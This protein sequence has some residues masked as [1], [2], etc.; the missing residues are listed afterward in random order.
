[1]LGSK[2]SDKEYHSKRYLP[3][4]SFPD[5]SCF[6]IFFPRVINSLKSPI[7]LLS[8]AVP[9]YQF[10]RW[11]PAGHR[12]QE[13]KDGVMVYKAIHDG[14]FENREWLPKGILVERVCKVFSRAQQDACQTHGSSLRNVSESLGMWSR[15]RACLAHTGPW[16]QPPV[17]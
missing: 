1:M 14:C 8:Q 3:R 10:L 15:G 12:W 6:P 7:F 13:I 16:V 4:I 9:L 5:L 2:E 11:Q 17:P